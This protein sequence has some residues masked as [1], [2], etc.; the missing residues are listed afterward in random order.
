M[1]YI[2]VDFDGVLHAVKDPQGFFSKSKMFSDKLAPHKDNFYI[3]VSSSWR[4][5]FDFDTL[6][7]AFGEELK[8]QVIGITPVL[9]E[10]LDDGGR[11]LEIKKYCL[12]NGIKDNQ[13]IAIDDMP[14]LFPDNFSNL[15]ITNGETGITSSILDKIEDF[16]KS[17]LLTNKIKP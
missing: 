5:T 16:V 8:S 11:Y 15:I 6:V 12:E 7:E 1:K 4:E 9:K 14:I 3:V 2:F 10:G 17:P 13:W